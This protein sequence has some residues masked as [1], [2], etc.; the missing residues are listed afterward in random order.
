MTLDTQANLVTFDGAR[1]HSVLPFIGERYS[2][3]FFTAD[4]HQRAPADALAKLRAC[5]VTLP[6]EG[7]WK[8]F[9][10]MLSPPKGIG[11]QS[12]HAFF[13]TRKVE[14]PGAHVWWKKNLTGLGD[15][16][17]RLVLCF[18]GMSSPSRAAM[19]RSCA[20]LSRVLDID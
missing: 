2:L 12:I 1:A 20:K 15:E 19:L 8:Y 3:F 17:L 14:K 11:T 9:T 5:H 16:A 13:G 6:A 10:N 4:E 7:V 18:I